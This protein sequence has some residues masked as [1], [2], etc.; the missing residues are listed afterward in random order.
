MTLK[1]QGQYDDNV[2]KYVTKLARLQRHMDDRLLSIDKAES[3]ETKTINALSND[4]AEYTKLHA[5]FIDYRHRTFTSESLREACSQRIFMNGVQDKIA[6]YLEMKY[7]IKVEPT[8]DRVSIEREKLGSDKL[9]RHSLSH[10]KVKSRRS[11]RRSSASV[12][13][14]IFIQQKIKAEVARK[15]LEFIDR[16][17][18]VMYEKAKLNA[19]S[20]VKR[21]VIDGKLKRLKAEEDTA[22]A[23]V[24]VKIL[25]DLP[26]DGVSDGES[27]WTSFNTSR[28]VENQNTLLK[29]GYAYPPGKLNTH[30]KKMSLVTHVIVNYIRAS[31][32]RKWRE[33]QKNTRNLTVNSQTDLSSAS[34]ASG[35]AKSTGMHSNKLNPQAE[36]F[37]PRTE[38]STKGTSEPKSGTDLK[39]AFVDMTNFMTKKRFIMDR[40]KPFFQVIPNIF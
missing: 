20:L 40:I 26:D 38:T 4:Y 37:K 29:S 14:D 2:E 17:N 34:V 32:H 12:T 25:E 31:D 28:Y 33:V 16:E 21:V 23:E 9:S 8:T 18:E 19:D 36:A 15:K 11:S 24:G 7:N 22:I 6:P 39:E 1:G 13:L 35:P 3:S 5:G 30:S 27:D 10:S